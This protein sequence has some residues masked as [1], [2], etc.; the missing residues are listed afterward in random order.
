MSALD[1]CR[2]VWE[3]INCSKIYG[4]M[5]VQASHLLSRPNTAHPFYSTFDLAPNEDDCSQYSRYDDLHDI[6]TY[7]G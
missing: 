3:C 7:D 1:A 4:A 6:S 5:L 2:I